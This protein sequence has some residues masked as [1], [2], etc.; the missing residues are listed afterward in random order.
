MG[1]AQAAFDRMA[2]EQR[3]TIMAMRRSRDREGLMKL[4]E[5]LAA[6]A[7]AEATA[8]P[9]RFTDEQRKAYTTVGGAPHLDGD[10]T[11]FGEVIDGMDIVDKI[12]Q[13]PTS[14]GDRP[15]EDVKI[16]KATVV[17]E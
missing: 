3:D 6:K 5:E 14:R 4:Q 17:E 10:Y 11:V 1:R 9:F 8:N 15:V 12:E 16:I 2:S 7:K 13:V